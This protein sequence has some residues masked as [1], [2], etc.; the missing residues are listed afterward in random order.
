MKLGVK[1]RWEIFEARYRRYQQTGKIL[2]EATGTTGVNRDHLAHV[3]ASYGK[4]QRGQG[5]SPSSLRE[6]WGRPPK[7]QEKTFVALL[8]CIRE[9][10]GRALRQTA[11][12]P[13]MGYNKFSGNVERARLR[14]QRRA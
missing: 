10:H 8:T 5:G 9:D 2:E 11:G 1:T 14:Y 13:D 7:Y 4:Q 12:A 6:G 3:L